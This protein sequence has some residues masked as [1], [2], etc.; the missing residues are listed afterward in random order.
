[1]TT[2]R[3]DFLAGSAAAAVWASTF[4]LPCSADAFKISLAEWSLHKALFGG[5]LDHLDFPVVTKKDYGIEGCELVN[6][7]FKDKAGDADYLKELRKRA[8]DNGVKILLIMIDGEG[9]LAQADAGQRKQAVENHR[10]WLEC[11]QS[12][13]CHSIRVNA[14]GDGKPEETQKHA[15]EALVALAELGKKPDI[16]VIVENHGGLSSD[17]KWLA[18]VMKLAN[19][20]RVGTLPDFGNFHE[21]DRYQGVADLMPYAKAVSAK[22]YDF[23]E[24]GNE[25][26]IDY[27]RMLKIVLDAGYRSWIGIEYEGGRLSEPDGILATKALLERIRAQQP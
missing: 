5:K 8:D 3:R 19:H 1:M 25:T 7:F 9:E 10:K 11:G 26:R 23:D 14:G 16:N 6:Q 17:G 27:P 12:L 22:S 24:Q 15:A 20:P 21:Y 18:G 13:G 4:R 2:T